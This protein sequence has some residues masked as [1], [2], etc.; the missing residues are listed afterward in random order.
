MFSD[1]A[2]LNLK[3]NVQV[4]KQ[5][6]PRNKVYWVRIYSMPPPLRIK[7]DTMSLFERVTVVI[8]SIKSSGYSIY[9]QL[10]GQN[11]EIHDFLKGSDPKRNA[12]RFWTRVVESFPQENNHYTS[13]LGLVSVKVAI[14]LKFL[15]SLIGIYREWTPTWLTACRHLSTVHIV[16]FYA[17]TTRWRVKL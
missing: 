8:P 11:R 15:L 16:R 12:N 1:R 6:I 14:I 2:N 7:C 5:K 17:S 10:V 4:S 3:I 13:H 9:P